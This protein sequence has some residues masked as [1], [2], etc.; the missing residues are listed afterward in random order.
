[1]R[2]CILPFWHD[3][4]NHIARLK[5]MYAL[6]LF[7]LAAWEPKRV[8]IDHSAIASPD[9]LDQQGLLL[10]SQLDSLSRLAYAG[11]IDPVGF[12]IILLCAIELGAT[13]SSH[14][15]GQAC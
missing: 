13:A 1:M 5:P 11:C 8:D 10:A 9:C 6:G 4:L 12:G 3:G 14:F 7:R 2:S 15:D